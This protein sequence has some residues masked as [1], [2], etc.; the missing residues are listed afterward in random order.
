VSGFVSIGGNDIDDN[1][2]V[3]TEWDEEEEDTAL[4][5]LGTLRNQNTAVEY[6]TPATN[7]DKQTSIP[8]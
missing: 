6:T 8:F 7:A 4:P 5:I 2:N 1:L 3:D